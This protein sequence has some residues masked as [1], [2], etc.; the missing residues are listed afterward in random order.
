MHLVKISALALTLSLAVS[1]HAQTV[2]VPAATGNADL[3][4]YNNN[5][6]MVRERRTFKMPGPAAQLV[7]GGV[8]RELQPETA[9]LQVLKGDA[10]RVTEQIFNFDVL[11]PS[12]L[13][14]RAVGSE[15]SVISVNPGNGREVTERARV[16]SVNEGL[17]LEIN[18][19]I[20]TNH[21]GRIVFDSIPAGVRARPTLI[22]SATGKGAQ[23]VDAELSYLTGGLS[24]HPDYVAQYDS[25]SNRMTLLA[26]ATV[27]NTTSS[28]FPNAKMKLI[29]GQVN[30]TRPSASPMP[31]MARAAMK[32]EAA[33][34]AQSFGGGIAPTAGLA[35][36]VYTIP[37][38][39]SLGPFETKQ[40]GLLNSQSIPVRRQI[41]VRAEP[42]YYTQA[43]RGVQPESRADVEL[44]FKN[45]AAAKL[46]MP[47]PAGVVRVYGSDSE[48]APQ[49]LGEDRID[50]TAVGG[51]VTLS[52][53]NDF[54]IPVQRE[55]LNYVR[56]T[57]NISITTWRVTISNA[58]SRPVTV[59][60]IE[61]I[62]GAWEIAKESHPHTKQDAGSA[63][64]TLEI[65]AKGKT[66]LEYSARI[67]M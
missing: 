26:W 58:K 54:D 19:K 66:V 33:D 62:P 2:D 45:D 30:R 67:T 28:D 18:G 22:M 8:P 10:V 63:L 7:M 20:H 32:A 37:K 9:F 52:L 44:M 60:V 46:G 31:M 57:D 48:G 50:H 43:M 36:Y 13:L 53:G 6:A 61:P 40:L 35:T 25:D 64:W 49:F 21:P 47:L 39:T 42:Y 11:T 15:V 1:A 3:T 17:V 38:L 23:D 4:I 65:P 34:M 41:T 59:R 56:A 16:L 12:K 5:F 51:E 29:A 14:E 24:W 55:Q 27:T